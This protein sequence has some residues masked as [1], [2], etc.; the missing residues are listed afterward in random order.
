MAVRVE[1]PGSEALKALGL[2]VER[3]LSLTIEFVPGDIVRA[4]AVYA[5]DVEQVDGMLDVVRTMEL[6]APE[7][8]AGEGNH[9]SAGLQRSMD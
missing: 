6:R 1:K 3:C 9:E 4:T 7:V 8:K 5:P 2:S